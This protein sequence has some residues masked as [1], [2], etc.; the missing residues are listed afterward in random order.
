MKL[1]KAI[2]WR[3][4][5]CHSI[6]HWVIFSGINGS[7]YDFP[8]RTN[9]GHFVRWIWSIVKWAR[10]PLRYYPNGRAKTIDDLFE[11]ILG[12]AEYSKIKPRME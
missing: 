7:I 10:T 6:A 3:L 11:E 9:R 5:A 8:I 4:I 12:K 2:R 1:Y